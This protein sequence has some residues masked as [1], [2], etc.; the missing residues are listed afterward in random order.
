M[1]GLS[2]GKEEGRE[3]TWRGNSIEKIERLV[4]VEYKAQEEGNS[5]DRRAGHIQ[6]R[7]PYKAF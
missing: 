2:W 5:Q 1:L 4:W 7:E 3:Y 6:C